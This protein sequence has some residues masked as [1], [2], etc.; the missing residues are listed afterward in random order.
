MRSKQPINT[1]RLGYAAIKFVRGF[2]MRLMIDSVVKVDV[3]LNSTPEF[4]CDQK[5]TAATTTTGVI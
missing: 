1:R 4:A 5:T 2:E 3:T